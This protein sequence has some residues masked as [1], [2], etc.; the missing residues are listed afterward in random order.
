VR[1]EQ[2]KTAEQRDR[3]LDAEE[4]AKTNEAR[5]LAAEKRARTNFDL[6]RKAVDDCYGV[7]LKHPLL[8]EPDAEPIKNLLLQKTQ[9]FYDNFRVQDDRDPDLALAQATY[10][11]RAGEIT[12]LIG[13]T[14]TAVEQLEKARDVVLASHKAHPNDR[15]YAPLLAETC[16]ALGLA[17]LRAGKYA[18]AKEAFRL[19]RDRYAELHRDQPAGGYDVGE[20]NALCNL[21]SVHADLGEADAAR[22]AFDDAEVILRRLLEAKP[23]EPSYALEM[24]GLRGSR[25]LLFL[26][27]G[28]AG[29]ALGELKACR[30]G[31]AA[32]LERHPRSGRIKQRLAVAH[33]NLGV[34]LSMQ[35]QG[36]PEAA[37]E[38]EQALNLYEQLHQ[39]YR[40]RVEYQAALART[41][42]LAAIKA[43]AGERK[44]ALEMLT[45]SKALYQKLIEEHPDVPRYRTERAVTCFEIGELQ[46][47]AG[48]LDEALK[49]YVESRDELQKLH[50]AYP[51]A[52]ECR[53]LLGVACNTVG[54]VH[55]QQGRM[56]EAAAEFARAR[57]HFEALLA[58]HP[59]GATY[60]I[61]LGNSLAGASLMHYALGDWEKAA[62]ACQGAFDVVGKLNKGSPG[63]HQADWLLATVA[64]NLGCVRVS[65]GR[66]DEAVAS[67]EKGEVVARKLAAE[68]PN[69][70]DYQYCHGYAC[71]TLAMWQVNQGRFEESAANA[72]KA[73]ETFAA[74]VKGHPEAV[75][76]R[77]GQAGSHAALA[78]SWLN[79]GQPARADREAAF[80]WKEFR[81]LCEK[82]PDV[83]EFQEGLALACFVRASFVKAEGAEARLDEAEKLLEKL[84]AAQPRR[85][86]WMMFQALLLLQRGGMLKIQRKTD[87]AL[88]AALKARKL[89]EKALAAESKNPLFRFTLATAHFAVGSIYNAQ[90]KP[91]A[92]IAEMEKGRDVLLKLHD[93][94]KLL[95]RQLRSLGQTCTSLGDAWMARKE[96]KKAVAEYARARD[97][98]A[99][100]VEADPDDVLRCRSQLAEMALLLGI[101]CGQLGMA[102]ESEKNFEL[103]R[104]E[105]RV[106]NRDGKGTP[107]SRHLQAR[108][109]LGLAR[110]WA[111]REELKPALGALD[112]AIP[113]YAAVYL[114]QPKDAMIRGQ[115]TDAVLGRA[116]LLGELKRF[117]E[118]AADLDRA[119]ELLADGQQ[120]WF[121]RLVRVTYLVSAGD[122]HGAAEAVRKMVRDGAPV[123]TYPDLAGALSMAAEGLSRDR[124]RPLPER[125]KFS[126]LWCRQALALLRKVGEEGL[127]GGTV[128]KL[129]KTH[130][131]LTFLRQRKDFQ[132]WLKQLEK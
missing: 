96:K 56:K 43:Q 59:D 117:A 80:A 15:R 2:E 122:R 69:V 124:S 92:G 22:K 107:D 77:S 105:G 90:N 38:F 78:R 101:Y 3:A 31:H 45:R 12:A 84:A 79:L 61:G 81:A 28:K 103:A 94:K 113:L 108:A 44:E 66:F 98:F 120:R 17:L 72:E 132:D 128:L 32:L 49:S 74:L 21:G 71:L 76:Y 64:V 93:E 100:V 14:T 10:L 35:S 126:E 125:E 99:A 40:H 131:S 33:K 27:S 47:R 67:L 91:A 25:G 115:Y 42:G 70:A 57:R 62:E 34:L 119:I 63:L 83:V 8:Q 37:R 95:P 52:E 4:E 123:E 86:E 36:T 24:A 114:A 60:Q 58:E 129:L 106:L 118:A 109:C 46:R 29:E 121:V 11:F 55:W 23:A 104:K 54:T 5:A 51:R 110:L 85:H 82:H 39:E 89:C 102:R 65:Q 130:E 30:D 20:A 13:K 48:R 16:N 53:Q 7:A 50:D 73:R 75:I 41:Q 116:A 6:A 26:N 127:V 1:A 68:H 112:E 88:E 18:E 9:P 87:E 97:A 111:G 19:A